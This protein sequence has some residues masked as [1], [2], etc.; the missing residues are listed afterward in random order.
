MNGGLTKDFSTQPH[1]LEESFL[2]KRGLY[3]AKMRSFW[4]AEGPKL[5]TR[6]IVLGGGEETQRTR[7][8]V[9][10]GRAWSEGATNQ[11]RPEAT[12]SWR[13]QGGP[14]LE[15][16][17]GRRPCPRL[18]FKPPPSGAGREYTWLL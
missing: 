18:D 13:R 6:G 2:W 17:G 9:D 16:P 15:A 11:G 3:R 1:D 10:L 7:M 12:R 8:C 5:P 4:V 14:S